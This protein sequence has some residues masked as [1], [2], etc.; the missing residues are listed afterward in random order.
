MF[1]KNHF[2]PFVV[3][4]IC[5]KMFLSGYRLKQRCLLQGW[6]CHV[7]SNYY[8]IWQ[9]ITKLYSPGEICNQHRWWSW[10]SSHPYA[11]IFPPRPM[12]LWQ[13]TCLSTFNRDALLMVQFITWSIIIIWWHPK[14]KR[15]TK[16]YS[17]GE[18][19]NQQRWWSLTSNVTPM[20]FFSTPRESL[21]KFVQKLLSGS[22]LVGSE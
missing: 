16:L 3:C 2:L 20:P 9:R 19:C 7:I 18:V 6:A 21:T 12:R 8:F 17:P 13:N 1:I 15:I 22:R 5:R 10:P 4:N 14:K 11:L